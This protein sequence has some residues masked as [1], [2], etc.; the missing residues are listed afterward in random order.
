M[1]TKDN[2]QEGAKIT[3]DNQV[4]G[5]SAKTDSNSNKEKKRK[6]SR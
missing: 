6:R 5:S 2:F 3:Q 1:K 4:F